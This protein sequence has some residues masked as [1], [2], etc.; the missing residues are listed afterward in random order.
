LLPRLLSFLLA[1]LVFSGSLLGIF[2]F[3]PYR[4]T[5]LS[6]KIHASFNDTGAL[7]RRLHAEKTPSNIS[8]AK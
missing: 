7:V 8:F 6:K 4:G 2:S 5:S 1:F 3:R